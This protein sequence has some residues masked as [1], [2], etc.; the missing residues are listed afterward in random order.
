M[1]DYIMFLIACF[2]FMLQIRIAF[3]TKIN[4]SM[5]NL[6]YKDLDNNRD[7]SWFSESSVFNEVFNPIHWNKWTAKQ[8]IKYYK[9]QK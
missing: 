1:F 6:A 2:L 8:W 9:K 3:I 4:I 5:A 7:I